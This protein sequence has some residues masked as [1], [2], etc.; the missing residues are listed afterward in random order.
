MDN[1]VKQEKQTTQDAVSQDAEPLPSGY[2]REVKT[3]VLRAGRMTAAQQKAYNELAPS[4]CIP[5]EEKK[6]NFVDIFGNTNPVIIEIG[7]GM[8]HATV[9]IAAKNPDINYLGIEVH[10][11]GVGRV[12]SEI[13]R[14][15]LKKPLS[16]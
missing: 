10:T 2:R 7:F 1:Q 8:G 5:F 13:N 12:L 14:L 3:Y 4:W 9:D 6:L 11:P 15:E 16:Y